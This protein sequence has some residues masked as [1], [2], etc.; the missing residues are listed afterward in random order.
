M[1]HRLTARQIEAAP[2][3]KYCDGDGLWLMKRT[4]GAGG[5]EFRFRLH[6]RDRTMSLGGWPS[7]SLASARKAHTHWR[8]LQ[9]SG[10]DPIAQRDR[11]KRGSDDTSFE[12]IAR[13]CFASRQTELKGDGKAGR[14]LSPLEHHVFPHIGRTPVQDITQRDLVQVLAPIWHTKAN[15]AKP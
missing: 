12:T 6:G 2:A 15:R 11:E 5:W 4:K 7:T 13:N 1:K 14:W 9:K 3:G 8:E 10:V